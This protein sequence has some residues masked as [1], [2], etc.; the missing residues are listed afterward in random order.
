MEFT[1]NT[2]NLSKPKSLPPLKSNS[3]HNDDETQQSDI[4]INKVDN[5]NN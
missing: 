4:P 5:S 1:Q 2:P 3:Q